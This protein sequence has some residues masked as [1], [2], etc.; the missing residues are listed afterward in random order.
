M[1]V[2]R[3]LLLLAAL[4]MKERKHEQAGAL[5][6]HAMAANDSDQL[7][8]HLQSLASEDDPDGSVDT[9]D[10][11]TSTDGS[12]SGVKRRKQKKV[13]LSSIIDSISAAIAAE[14]EDSEDED[15]EE[16]EDSEADD[17][18]AAEEEEDE[19]DSD[20]SDSDSEDDE[21]SESDDDSETEADEGKKPATT[22]HKEVKKPKEEISLIPRVIASVSSVAVLKGSTPL[23]RR[24]GK[25]VVGLT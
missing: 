12:G 9:G 7:L 14:D 13:I 5:F 22:T 24:K 20:D 25:S 11:S 16:D 18:A 19:E 21:S 2:S 15:D 17:S 6:Y 23:L 4:A 10:S 3:D 8:Q 1:N